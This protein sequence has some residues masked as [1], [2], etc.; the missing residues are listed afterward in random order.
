MN[1]PNKKQMT[2]TT[3][4]VKEAIIKPMMISLMDSLNYPNTLHGGRD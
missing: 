2:T 4:K 1:K 3:T